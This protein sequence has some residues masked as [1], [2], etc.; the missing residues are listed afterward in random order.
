MLQKLL[1]PPTV[2]FCENPT[3][4][5]IR[6]PWYALSNAT[7]LVVGIVILKS[8]KGDSLSKKFGYLAIL[9][10]TL[11]FFYDASYTYASQLLDNAG[12]FV[13][14]IML[15]ALNIS[16]ICKISKVAKVLSLVSLV[17]IGLIVTMLFGGQAGQIVF[18]VFILAY[19]TSELYLYQKKLHEN[20]ID[21]IIGF[22]A[23]SV[24][25][26]F[27]L[28]DATKIFCNPLPLLNGR[29][30]FHYLTAVTI[31][32]LYLFYASQKD[33]KKVK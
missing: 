17:I 2:T 24:G 22:I 1:G 14:V 13:F 10:G 25:F 20:Y 8:G 21:W 32:Y 27:W 19:I 28:P 12:M 9:I 3:G 30:I 4:G 31:Y 26:A 7:F 29:A 16:L 5:L 11:S 18:G 15:L 23:F 6:R 33:N